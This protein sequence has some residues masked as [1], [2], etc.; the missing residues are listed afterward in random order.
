[1]DKVTR[2]EFTKMSRK[3]DHLDRRLEDRGK[4][5]ST[6]LPVTASQVAAWGKLHDSEGRRPL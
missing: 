5:L 4:Q 3:L 2:D 6:F 1:M